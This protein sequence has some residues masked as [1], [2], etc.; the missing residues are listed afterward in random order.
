MYLFFKGMDEPNLSLKPLLTPTFRF[1]YEG[2]IYPYCY[3]ITLTE[4][5]ITVKKLPNADTSRHPVQPDTN[6]LTPQE[7]FFVKILDRDF[8]IDHINPHRLRRRNYLDSLGKRYPQLLDP[9]YYA[10]LIK[11]EGLVKYRH[12]NYAY[13][14]VGITPETYRNLIESI[15]TSGFWQFPPRLPPESQEI[16]VF[17]AAGFILEA[18]TPDK[19]NMVEGCFCNDD[20]TKRFESIL[21]ALV[22]AAGLHDEFFPPGPPVSKK[23][24]TIDSITLEDIKPA[25]KKHHPKKPHPNSNK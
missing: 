14:E 25:P 2:Y 24:L 7:R 19:Y 16:D 9:T 13:K 23:A 1:V 18:N 6:R 11:K 21:D 22:D 12:Y 3:T 5:E 4:K 17:D 10:N 20:S 8:P 15:D